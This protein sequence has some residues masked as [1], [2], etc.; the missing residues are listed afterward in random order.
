MR[1]LPELRRSSHVRLTA[2]GE[3]LTFNPGY[4]PVGDNFGVKKMRVMN[5]LISLS[6]LHPI[7]FQGSKSA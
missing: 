6:L 1:N 7:T 5:T 4:Q 3:A 2:L